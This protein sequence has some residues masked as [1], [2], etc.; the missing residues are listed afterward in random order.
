MTDGVTHPEKQP[1]PIRSTPFAIVISLPC[2]KYRRSEAPSI[3]IRNSSQIVNFE[4]GLSNKT[5][6]IAELDIHEPLGCATRAGMQI[7]FSDEQA[8]NT[9]D[10]R[11]EI[12]QSMSNVT[13]ARF[14]HPQKQPIPMISI[15]EGIQTDSS[16]RHRLNAESPRVETLQPRSNVTA[17]RFVHPRKQ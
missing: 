17:E 2:P 9:D 13:V 5:S 15:D 11:V 16:D 3:P 4:V 6:S 7:D 12:R 8:P 14:V 1:E 10:P